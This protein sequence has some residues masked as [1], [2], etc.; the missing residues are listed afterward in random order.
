M[1]RRAFLH[2]LSHS[3]ALPAVFSGIPWES[4]ASSTVLNNTIGEGNILIM[5]LLNGG[6]DGLNT[7]I[8]LNMMSQ[9]NKVR[10]KV[11]LPENKLLALNKSDLALHPSLVGLHG[12]SKENRL[13]II[14]SVGYTNPNYSHFRSMDIIQSGATS[15]EFLGSGWIGRY[16]EK[17]HPSYPDAYPTSDYPHPLAV[18]IGWN[19]SLM[20]TGQ[21]SFTS[22]V[23][24]SP[25]NFYEIVGD[26][27]QAYPSSPFGEKLKYVQLIA[28]QSN[29]YGKVM[30]KAYQSGKEFV[31]P[32]TNLSNQFKILARLISG[33]LNTRIFKV[34]IGGFDTH[35][36]QVDTSD[37]TKGTHA[38]LLKE[39]DEAISTFMKSMDQINQSDRILGMCFSEFGRTVGSNDTYGTDHGATA[40][41][42][43]FGNH[44]DANVAGINPVIPSTYTWQEELPMQFDFK[45]IYT[46]IISQWLGGGNTINNL[47]SKEYPQL[48]IIKEEF[49]DSDEDG[50]GDLYDQCANTPIGTLVDV[51]GCEIF[52]LPSDNYEVGVANLTCKGTKNGSIQ[53]KVKNTTFNYAVKLY[54]GSNLLQTLAIEKGKNTCLFSTLGTDNYTINIQ[55][56]GK[57]NY[58]QSFEAKITEPDT[59]KVSAAIS[60]TEKLLSLQVRGAESYQVTVNGMSK[61]YATESVKIPIE[62]GPVSLKVSTQ[63]GCQGVYEEFLFLS[64]QAGCF[65]NPTKDLTKIYVNGNDS[66]VNVQVNDQQGRTHL[67]TSAAI[68]ASRMIELQMESYAPGMYFIQLSGEHVRQTLKLIKL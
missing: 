4:L 2:N 30:Q 52:V 53:V 31:F 32:N 59:L 49:R 44:I 68:D 67:S 29:A 62:T 42:I 37:R 33:G 26:F 63:Y 23:A 61:E 46:S 48:S 15:T 65:P 10:P 43:M 45:Q 60:E 66:V 58:V 55:I 9:L 38:N 64:E 51:T 5:V 54:A 39:L 12:L 13:K 24:S 27:E 1:N 50:V 17:K 47:F 34:E 21:K 20:F 22:V 28:K 14:Q 19:S 56:E 18:E 35:G 57:A 25:E 16:L 3:I 11:V 7:V 40:P 6:N 36:N 8:P 41:V